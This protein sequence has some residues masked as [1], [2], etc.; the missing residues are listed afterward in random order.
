MRFYVDALCRVSPDSV[1]VGG[2]VW[3]TV[4]GKPHR[5]FIPSFDLA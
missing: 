3:F 4:A 2:C 1:G 5:G